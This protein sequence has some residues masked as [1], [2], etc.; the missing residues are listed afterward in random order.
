MTK[1][2]VLEPLPYPIYFVR[3]D[4]ELCE[5]LAPVTEMPLFEDF[6][7]P[8]WGGSSSWIVQTYLQLKC[9]G[10]DVRLVAQFVPGAICV[11]SREELMK[12]R[13]LQGLPFRSYVVVCQ[14][15]R[16]RP[17]ICDHR[18]VQNRLNIL[19]S[20]D[21]YMPHWTQPDLRS[22]HPVRGS[23]VE[24]VVFKGR[25]YYLP[26]PYKNSN[27]VERLKSLGFTFI[28]T[29]DYEVNLQDWSDYS[30]ADVLLALRQRSDLY[31]E[32]KPPTK[33]MNAWMAGCPALLGPEPAYQELRKS[34][35]DYLEVDSPEDV[36]HA[37]QRL[38]SNPA[39]YQAMVENGR[40]RA[41]EF[42]ADQ[43]ALRW[44]NLLAADI[45]AGYEQWQNQSFAWKLAARPGRFTYQMLLQEQERRRFNRLTGRNT[46]GMH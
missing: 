18:I 3:N 44:R 27:F 32:S 28:T 36:I 14:Q 30:E 33:L 21:H 39:L 23:R 38:R 26:E 34:E 46:S 10:L 35:L 6:Y 12:R 16:P 40:L 15:D 43:T 13:L 29:A 45:A 17:F 37:L 5:A 31:L 24:N 25:W 22:R 4:P 2:P 8:E 1:Q 9:R 7:R 20:R 41:E 11:V 42:T 19:D